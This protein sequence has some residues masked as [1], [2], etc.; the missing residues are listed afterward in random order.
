MINSSLT[1]VGEPPS[2]VSND[3]YW[4]FQNKPTM[5]LFISRTHGPLGKD[6]PKG[7]KVE[8]TIL[9]PK[10]MDWCSREGK[11]GERSSKNKN[12]IYQKGKPV[13]PLEYTSQSQRRWG[14]LF[15]VEVLVSICTLE[16]K[17]NGDL[18]LFSLHQDVKL[19]RDPHMWAVRKSVYCG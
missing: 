5:L 1:E 3:K 19:D 11:Q 14:I 2:S 10:S 12:F 7:I 15:N 18:W 8:W 4:I 17:V 16:H 13:K 9:G 6:Y